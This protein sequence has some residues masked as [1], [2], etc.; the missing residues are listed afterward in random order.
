MEDFGFSC[1]DDNAIQEAELQSESH[2]GSMHQD[3][4]VY[5]GLVKLA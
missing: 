3:S 2:E 1:K 4:N 5:K